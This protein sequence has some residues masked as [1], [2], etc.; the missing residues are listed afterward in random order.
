M[1]NEDFLRRSLD[2]VWHPCTQMKLHET[3][4]LVPIRRG[5]AP[6]WRI[7][8]AAAIWMPSVPGG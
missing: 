5:K 2:A 6:G 8:T 3:L 4:P 1:N 7:S